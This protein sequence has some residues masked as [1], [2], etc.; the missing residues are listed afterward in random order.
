MHPV[1][2]PVHVLAARCLT[3]VTV[4]SAAAC[5]ERGEAPREAISESFAIVG[6]RLGDRLVTSHPLATGMALGKLASAQ[7]GDGL[8]ELN[9]EIGKQLVASEP[10]RE[11]LSFIV[12]CALPG[13]VAVQA[14]VA[15]TTFEFYGEA[16][17]APGW[18]DGPLDMIQQRWVSA[19]MFARMN[20][21]EVALAVSMR[22]PHP[23]LGTDVDERDAFT[24]QEGAFFGNYFTPRGQPIEWYACRGS[25]QAAGDHGDLQ[26]RQCAEPDPARAGLTKCGFNYAGE[27][28]QAAL[29][30][31]CET[32]SN[33]GTYYQRCRAST[34]GKRQSPFEPVF[35][36]VIT[37]YM[38]P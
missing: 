38:M 1:R 21:H 2:P 7:V 34:I 35:S 4:M 32:F 10:G 29:S 3:V 11:V 37:T 12:G 30:R 17:M 15:D 14:T 26:F 6:N 23:S 33:G 8:Y 9:M 36:Q 31:A 5:V 20:A 13:T 16:G 27:C 28:G 22:G 19:C 18:I 25:D 24:L